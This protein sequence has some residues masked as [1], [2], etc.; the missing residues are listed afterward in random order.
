M[1]GS[2]K[3]SKGP[4]LPSFVK[5]KR[6]NS[7]P[8]V[9]SAR[10]KAG[11]SSSTKTT[12]KAQTTQKSSN[13][14]KVH[15]STTSKSKASSK[16]KQVSRTQK[17][18]RAAGILAA[19]ALALI[20]M[21]L[22]VIKPSEST[23]AEIDDSTV[24]F[25]GISIDGVNVSGKA[26]GE[27]R[28]L[29]NAKVQA[30]ISSFSISLLSGD[31]K[32]ALTS[33]DVDI[34]DDVDAVLKEAILTG[35]S[36]SMVQNNITVNEL[37]AN[38]RDFEINYS[39][40]DKSLEQYVRGIAEQANKPAQ[41]PYAKV[42]DN[43]GKMPFEFIDGSDGCILDETAL[44]T[45][46]KQL[47]AEKSYS[48]VITLPV[49]TT[50]PNGSIEDIKANI[51]RIAIFSTTFKSGDSQKSRIANIKKAAGLLN[52]AIINPGEEFSFN[53]FIGPRTEANGWELALGITG[54]KTYELQAGGGI[55]QVSTTLYNALLLSDME[56]TN[57]KKHTWPSS[58]V[59]LG[60]DAT[61]STGGPD[62]KFRN[63][64]DHPIYIIAKADTKEN[65][66]YISIF[67]P[68]LEE[69][70]SYKMRSVV[71]ET[72]APPEP[73]YIDDDTVLIGEQVELVTARNGYTVEVYRDKYMNDKLASSELLYTD[74]YKAI[75]GEIAVGTAENTGTDPS[76]S[77]PTPIPSDSGQ[78]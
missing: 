53:D 68:A 67:G 49:N 3:Y 54:G 5:S 73:K 51:N 4:E 11:A 6:P 20:A 24:F 9:S 46:L 64:K 48:A 26:L 19:I 31:D 35:R 60:L 14:S 74:S 13:T 75:Q 37:K 32:W 15:A 12:R 58:Y 45:Q 23:L 41:E 61:V 27:A 44:C 57:R 43:S 76:Q 7:K 17:R 63:N 28:Q 62:L 65:K 29:V 38:G 33:N 40:T 50:S 72:I 39:I 47:I 78:L 1:A 22:F 59:D 56:I 8:A 52:G 69:G 77:V 25:T 66:M 10:K 55:C 34:T 30:Q 71:I 70:V 18:T 16:K 2:D 42:V 21:W 36:G